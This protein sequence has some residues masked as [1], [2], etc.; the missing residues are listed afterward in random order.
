MSHHILV[1]NGPNLNLLGT[2]EP[3]IYGSFSLQDI[4]KEMTHSKPNGVSLTFLQSNSESEIIDTLHKSKDKIQG[5]IINPAAFTHTSI[6]I[7]DALS[8][9][10]IPTI[11]VHISNTHS[12]ESFRHVSYIS[13]VA[14][15]VIAG[16]GL[17]GYI[18]ALDALVEYLEKATT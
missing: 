4:E 14:I 10:S 5:I 1:I 12:R 13:G 6:A 11:E 18:Y 17:K 7:R 3:T 15:G 8:A 9:V 2:R 16:F